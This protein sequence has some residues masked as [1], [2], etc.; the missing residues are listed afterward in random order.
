VTPGLP[1]LLRALLARDA[2]VV[3]VG[4]PALAADLAGAGGRLVVAAPTA[5]VDVAAGLLTG[6]RPVVTVLDRGGAPVPPGLAPHVIV[7]PD[8]TTAA[9]LWATGTDV[10][11]PV[12]GGDPGA[13][14]DACL[15]AGRPLA[16]RLP[17]RTDGAAADAGGLAPH[18]L[19][20][21]EA[22]AIVTAGGAAGTA[23]TAARMLAA[24]GVAVGAIALPV[25]P[26]G[27]GA[28]PGR[29]DGAVR[30]VLGRAAS[31]LAASGPR[32]LV[33][34]GVVLDAPDPRALIEAV[35][36][37]ANRPVATP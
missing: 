18:L 10:V 17:E 22:G 13:L 29:W 36:A 27:R 32:D 8:A 12:G 21:G 7:V 37:A 14:L 28:P 11:Q 5:R 16:L 9:L 33:E 35:L 24:R 2:R 1:A 19:R 4:G 23:A 31:A 34:S 6:G 30:L 26:A 15:A 25:L 3:V 20:D